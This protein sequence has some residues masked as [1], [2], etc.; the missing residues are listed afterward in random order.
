MFQ[1]KIILSNVVKKSLSLQSKFFSEF[2][3]REFSSAN[4]FVFKF[5]YI[6]RTD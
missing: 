2:S 5:V 3:V 4:I 1:S 6:V